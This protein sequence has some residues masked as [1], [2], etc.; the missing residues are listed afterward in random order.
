MPLS[1]EFR[2]AVPTLVLAGLIATATSWWNT[3]VVQN[4]LRYRLDTVEKQEKTNAENIAASANQIQNQA[5]KFAEISAS[6]N[7]MLEQLR[8][9]RQEQEEIRRELRGK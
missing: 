9:I 2:K 1:E 3:Q 7:G 5:V 6:Q 4:E 8:E